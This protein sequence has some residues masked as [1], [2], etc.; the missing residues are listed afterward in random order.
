M[1]RRGAVKRTKISVY[2]RDETWDIGTAI[3][4]ALLGFIVVAILY[5]ALGWLA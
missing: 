3:D 4:A 1:K 5:S 2:M